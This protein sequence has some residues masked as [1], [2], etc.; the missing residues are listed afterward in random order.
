MT[1]SHKNKVEYISAAEILAI[2]DRII[3]AIGGIRGIRDENLLQSAAV[4][5]QMSFGGADMYK[6]IWTKAAILMEGIAVFHPFSDGNKR[7]SITAASA[8]LFRNGYEIA[9]PVEESE[10]MVLRVA[11]KQM[12]IEE[13]ST[14]LEKHS[15]KI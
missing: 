6:D 4:R 11:Q 8:F 13:I 3:E 10:E 5:P 9:L 7:T 12:S 14:W 15:K 1:A 2:H